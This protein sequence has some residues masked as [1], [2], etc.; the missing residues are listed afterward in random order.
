M[1]LIVANNINEANSGFGTDT[2]KVTIIHADGT[3]EKLPLMS[4][5]E[6]GN[7]ILDRV[8]TGFHN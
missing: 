6:V 5:Y 3:L 1:D 7:A 2:N 8:K 4:K